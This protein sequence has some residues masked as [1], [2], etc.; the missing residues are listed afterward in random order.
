[1]I[2]VSVI[3]PVYRVPLDYLRSC[4]DSLIV[5]TMQESE[6]IIISD[7]ASETECAICEEFKVKDS[8][9]KFFRREHAG[10]SA[11]RNYGIE[12]AQGEYITFVD[13]DDWI[14]PDLCLNSYKYA[15]ETESDIVLWE[16]AQNDNGTMK[17]AYF[18]NN[19]INKLSAEQ[20]ETIISNIIYTSSVQYNSASLV[21]CKLFK[22]KLIIQS[23]IRYP[24]E[25]TLS[26][27][28]VFNILAYRNA[29]KISYLN[30]V[31][32]F[33][34][35]HNQS[36]SHKYISDAFEEYCKFIH[37]LD[38]KTIDKHATAINN[39]IIR[40]YFF[41]WSSCYLHKDNPHPFCQ[42]MLKLRQN[43]ESNPFQKAISSNDYNTFSK[44]IRIEISCFKHRI[45]LP[46]YLHGLKAFITIF[47]ANKNKK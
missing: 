6:F 34:R 1:M 28:R 26:E 43:A 38:K 11:T 22:K 46:I 9:F 21:C 8:R 7:G 2:K 29:K 45:Y 3:V 16:A 44:L 17:H 31:M 18:S 12:H 39:E 32:Y 37:F 23:N 33:Y 27:D 36:T 42:R 20:V 41:S 35:I 13:S 25:L 4:L 10:V 5:Q 15:K 47:F 30:S 24:E 14:D 40:V 19:P